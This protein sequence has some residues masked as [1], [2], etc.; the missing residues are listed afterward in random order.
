MSQEEVKKPQPAEIL[1]STYY[2]GGPALD[3][4]KESRESGLSFN[5]EGGSSNGSRQ[6]SGLVKYNS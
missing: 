6:P 5:L 3:T 2:K 4:L 1:S